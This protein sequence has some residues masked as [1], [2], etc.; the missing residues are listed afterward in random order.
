MTVLLKSG[1]R[2]CNSRCHN[3]KNPP[4]K[5]RCIC[6]GENHNFRH[7][8]EQRLE[9]V[10]QQLQDTQDQFG[11]NQPPVS[12]PAEGMII[13]DWSSRRVHINA[14]LLS[15]VPSQAIHNHSPDGFNWS[16]GGSGPSQLALAILLKFLPRSEAQEHYQHFKWDIIATLPDGNFSLPVAKVQ[17]WI[18][19]HRQVPMLL[20]EA[21]A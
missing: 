11:V 4:A 16:Y 1:R 10:Q 15:P 13:G 7:Q 21:T 14:E 20:L 18:A 2:V 19:A 3:A 6:A 9:E 12:I 17:E 5:C 8:R